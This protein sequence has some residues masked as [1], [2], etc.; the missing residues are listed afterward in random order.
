MFANRAELAVAGI[1]FFVLFIVNA[2]A[3][4]ETVNIEGKTLALRECISIALKQNPQAEISRQN[5]KAAEEKIGEALGGYYPSFKFSSA[6]TYTAQQSIMPIGPDA[7][8]SRFF[9]RQPLYDAGG[10]SAL[11]RSIRHTAAAQDYE[12]KR[13]SFDIVLSVKSAYFDVLKKRDLREVSKAALVAAEKRLAQTKELYKEGVAPRSDVIKSE[14]HVSN[15]RFDVI[16]AE[17]A[18]LSAK[19]NLSSAMGQTVTTD[20][21]IVSP[22]TALLPALPAFKDVLLL[23]YDLRP[24]LKINRARIESA[25][26][27]ADQAKSG[28]YPYLS[29]DASYGWQQ[30]GFSPGDRKWSIGLTVGIPIFEQLTAMAKISQATAGLNGLKATEMQTM[31]NIELDV[32]QSWLALKEAME[33]LDVTKKTLEQAQEDI[34]VSD[35]RYKEGLGNI[36]EVID[37]QTTLTQAKTNNVV[38]LYDIAGA[39]AKLDRAT[40]KDTMEDTNK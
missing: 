30:G 6:Y 2:N 20:F 7:Y 4:N 21:D 13:V 26:A 17:N 5:L 23:A 14:V 19:A 16:K 33:R 25:K 11:V 9:L 24:E 3:Q 22:D 40:G 34:Q 38:T 31:R 15:A 37:A 29:L 32:R 39:S 35:G 18:F 1:L 36:L 28:L 8:D 27:S 12:V 10:V